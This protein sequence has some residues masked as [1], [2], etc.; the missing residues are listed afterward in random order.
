MV[1]IPDVSILFRQWLQQPWQKSLHSSFH[2][3][4]RDWLT[5]WNKVWQLVTQISWP[6]IKFIWG[7]E[8]CTWE[9]SKFCYICYILE[10]L[11]WIGTYI[12]YCFDADFWEQYTFWFKSCMKWFSFKLV[13]FTL[14]K[15]TWNWECVHWSRIHRQKKLTN[16]AKEH[17]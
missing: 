12:K 14:R 8:N 10:M 15:G 3:V 16:L 7:K 2:L 11:C 6:C 9:I 5:R 1:L 4:N 17:P 13:F